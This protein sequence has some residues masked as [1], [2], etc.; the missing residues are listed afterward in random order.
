MIKLIELIRMDLMSSSE[1]SIYGNKYFLSILYDYSRY[2]W[3]IFLKSKAD[4]FDA[5]VIWYN[6]IKNIFNKTIK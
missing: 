1:P 5:F 4:T 6:K 3:V 2:G